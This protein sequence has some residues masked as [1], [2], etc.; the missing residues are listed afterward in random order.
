MHN[1]KYS[2]LI[3]SACMLAYATGP[4]SSFAQSGMLEEV[5]VTAEKARKHGAGYSYRN[6]CL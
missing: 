1:Y 2:A 5:I 4:A 3:F 6:I